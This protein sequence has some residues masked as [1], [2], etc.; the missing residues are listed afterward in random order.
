MIAMVELVRT[1]A[2]HPVVIVHQVVLEAVVKVSVNQS[3]FAFITILS[4]A[5]YFSSSADDICTMYPCA[6]N[7]QCVPE[8]NSRRCICSAPYYGD[9]CR[10]GRTR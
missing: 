8:G 10:E 5:R 9:D 6:N 2:E 3:E 1:I 4:F 7:G